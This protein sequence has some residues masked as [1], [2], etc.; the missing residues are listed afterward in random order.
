MKKS[1]HETVDAGAG[2]GVARAHPEIYGR[3]DDAGHQEVDGPGVVLPHD[4]HL[5]AADGGRVG[6]DHSGAGPGTAGIPSLMVHMPGEPLDKWHTSFCRNTLRAETLWEA[7]AKDGWKSLLI[8]WPV[9]WP[10]GGGEGHP[11]RRLAEPALPLFLH[12][13]LGHRL[14]VHFF[15]QGGTLQPGARPRGEG[16]LR[17]GRRVDPPPAAQRHG[18][19]DP[20]S[21]ATGLRQGA[22]LPR[23]CAG[24]SRVRVRHGRHLGQPQRRPRPSRP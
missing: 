17:A 4:D 18:H 7:G 1:K 15:E 14:I 22:G 16:R 8:N 19:G 10:L 24:H 3:G 2:C 12:A 13:A 5:P 6:R 20:D 11:A 21:G 23:R 9:T